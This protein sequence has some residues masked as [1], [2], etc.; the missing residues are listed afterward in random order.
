MLRTAD[1]RRWLAA[2]LC[3][4]VAVWPILGQAAQG[5]DPPNFEQ[6][7]FDADALRLEPTEL[8]ELVTALTA[9]ASN[10]PEKD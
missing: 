8:V 9:L 1:I 7:L 6:R 3:L 10:F 5:F 2:G 4:A